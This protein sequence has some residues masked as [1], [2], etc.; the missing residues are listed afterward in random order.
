GPETPQATPPATPAPV[1]TAGPATPAGTEPL[2]LDVLARK[3]RGSLKEL[4]GLAK[5]TAAV[6]RELGQHLI[7][8]QELVKEKGDSWLQWLKD[9]CKLTTRQAQKYKRLAEHWDGLVAAG[10]DPS[11]YSIDQN[12]ALLARLG[13]PEAGTGQTASPSQPAAVETDAR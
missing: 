13:T 1:A 11:K 2:G 8:A 12:L 7:R 10:H 6:A 3:I 4:G 5:K 9:H